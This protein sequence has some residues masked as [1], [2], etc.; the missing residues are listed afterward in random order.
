MAKKHHS[1]IVYALEFGIFWIVTALVNLIPLAW[2]CAWGRALAWFLVCVAG[3]QRTRTYARIRAVFPNKTPRAARA[4][5]VGSLANVILN[6]LEMMRASR[7]SP[8]WIKRY[9]KEAPLYAARLKELVDE[10]KG[11]VI[12]VPH[13]GNWYMAAWAMASLGLPLVAVAARQRNPYMNAWMKRQYGS[14]E[15]IER[16]HPNTLPTIRARLRAG[17]AFA[18]LPDLRV[19]VRDVEVPFLNGTANVSHGGALLAVTTG[20]PIVVAAMRREGS[21]HTFDHIATLRPN[22]SAPHAVE[23]AK[24]LTREVMHLLDGAIQQ[25]PEH[26]F[27]YNKRWILQPI[28]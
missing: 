11:V 9:V 17:R 25:T 1:R 16:G 23:E 27:W 2:A 8:K 10:G 26:W 13:T 24:R 18:I 5:A 7:L 21:L 3:F 12:F 28:H 14:I 15:V 20:A 19:P 6:A 22:P 4:I